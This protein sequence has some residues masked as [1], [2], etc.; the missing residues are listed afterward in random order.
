M[1]YC[2]AWPWRPSILRGATRSGWR[3]CW[4]SGRTPSSTSA[5]AASAGPRVRRRRRTRGSPPG[6]WSVGA[7]PS[8]AATGRARRRCIWPSGECTPRC[9][10]GR[11]AARCSCRRSPPAP[12]WRHARTRRSW[13][14]TR[15]SHCSWRPPR[16][17]TCWPAGCCWSTTRTRCGGTFRARP[18]S[19][20][21]SGMRLPSSCARRC[22]TGAFCRGLWG[23]RCLRMALFV[24]TAS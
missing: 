14:R 23:R 5:P 20:S 22:P 6:R 4:T 13:T 21:A 18:P 19:T 7:C 10:A 11:P 15:V 16:R 3:T 2:S 9:E 12:C 17:V 24:G 8:T 1:R